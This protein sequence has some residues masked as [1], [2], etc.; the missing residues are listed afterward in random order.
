MLVQF[1]YG[2][3][4][5]NVEE[6]KRKG[7]ESK[8]LFMQ[9]LN[10]N[11]KKICVEN[12]YPLKMFELPKHTQI[13]QPYEYGHPFMKRT[14]LWLKGL[15]PLQPTHIVQ[16][17]QSTKIAGNWFNKGGK[18]RQANRSKTFSG[19]ARAMAQQW[20]KANQQT[21]D[22]I[23]QFV[24]SQIRH[25]ACTVQYLNKPCTCRCCTP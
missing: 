18:E 1:Y 19:I 22:E 6:R 12:P 15:P 20:G 3:K 21:E 16:E 8:H 9:L 24:V 13:I 23:F 11:I 4:A 2:R 7:F 10:A 14:C 5:K 25:D 17:R